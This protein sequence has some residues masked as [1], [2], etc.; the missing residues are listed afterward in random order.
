MSA[1]AAVKKRILIIDDDREF[2]EELQETLRLNDYEVTAVEDATEAMAIA[3]RVAP[4]LILL[5]LKMPL[6]SGFQ[7]ACKLKYFSHLKSVPIIAM[8]GYFRESYLPLLETYRIS[9]YIRKPF[10]T[11]EIVSKIENA[12]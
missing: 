7:V 3:L 11:V 5:D 9:A 2:L 8:T 4:D 6:E 10:G 12:F 1:A